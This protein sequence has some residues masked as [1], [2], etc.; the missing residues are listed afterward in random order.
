MQKI[1]HSSD[2]KSMNGFSLLVMDHESG[3]FYYNNRQGMKDFEK[4]RPG[5]VYGLSNGYLNSDWAKVEAGCHKME[6]ILQNQTR[7]RQ[8]QVKELRDILTNEDV[9]KECCH[10]FVKGNIDYRFGTVS[11]AVVLIPS[12]RGNMSATAPTAEKN[13][14]PNASKGRVVAF[15]EHMY[16]ITGGTTNTADFKWEIP[17]AE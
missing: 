6:R 3:M 15:S 16:D 7:Q 5:A 13:D 12:M 9:G 17:I 10:A 11:N 2:L 1:V 14:P 4:L 8:I